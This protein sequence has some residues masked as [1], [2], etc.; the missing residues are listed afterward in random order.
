M[1]KKPLDIDLAQIL[2]F[3]FQD[4]DWLKKFLIAS[5]LVLF[6]FIPVIPLVLLLGYA[7]EIIRRIAVDHESP[8]LPEWDDLSLYF[9][10]GIRLF[11][12]GAVYMV[13]AT[14]PGGNRRDDRNRSRIFYY[15]RLSG[16]VWYDGHWRDGI[17]VDRIDPA[18]RGNPCSCN[19]R[20]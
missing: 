11:G 18:D 6:S 9:N 1:A 4:Q 19:G 15:H 20:F 8:S 10:E 13:P 12:V 3:P 5:L 14:S 2:T 16:R 7:A 17:F